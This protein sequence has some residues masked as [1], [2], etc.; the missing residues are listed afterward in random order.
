MKTFAMKIKSYHSG[1]L[2]DFV[3]L[4]D[5]VNLLTTTGHRCSK[6]KE[7]ELP[8]VMSCDIVAVKTNAFCWQEIFLPNEVEIKV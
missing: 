3:I 2:D 6:L 4:V 5:F 1:Y 8:A 7:T